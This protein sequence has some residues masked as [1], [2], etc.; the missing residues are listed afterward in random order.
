MIIVV[1]LHYRHAPTTTHRDTLDIVAKHSYRDPKGRLITPTHKRRV[2]AAYPQ[3]AV[4]GLNEGISVL[5]GL[6]A[7]H[8]DKFVLPETADLEESAF[9]LVG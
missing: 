4:D 5:Y 2:Q 8:R 7:A 6:L 9:R 3:S 1:E